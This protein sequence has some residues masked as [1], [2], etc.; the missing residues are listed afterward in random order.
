MSTESSNRL[1][2]G[3]QRFRNTAY[4]IENTRRNFD[5]AYAA[6]VMGLH[7]VSLT[8][9]AV[10]LANGQCITD[11]VRC[12]YLGL[13]NHP[14]VVAGALAAIREYSSVH[15]SCARTRL[16]FRLLEDLEA[17]LSA[18]FRCRTIAYS[19]VMLAN[20]GALP[21]IASGYLTDGMKPIVVFDRLCHVSLAYHKP[22]IADETEVVTI[23][24]N[25]VAALEQICRQHKRVAYI[26]DGVY[27]M[28]GYAPIEALRALQQ[29]YGLFLYID[30]AHGISIHGERGQGYARSQFPDDLGPATIIAASLG[31]GFGASGGIL[32]LGTEEQ[33]N[34]F[35]RYSIPYAFSAAPNLA[36]V[37]A[38]LG[39][40][41]IHESEELKTLQQTLRKR[42]ELFDALIPTEQRGDPLPIRLVSVGAE[43]NAIELARRLLDQGF[44]TSA[45]FF[46]TVARGK[47]GIRI[48]VTA[49]H[50]ADEIETLCGA[51]G[52]LP[53]QIAPREGWRRPAHA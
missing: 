52:D 39:A 19:T 42:I 4:V 22:V 43:R 23:P 29:R 47:A 15:W 25:D 48:C 26:A 45:I 6:G 2:T 12:S 17:R 30:D 10:R 27:S 1:S 33:E 40:T 21:L 11:F 31:K 35:R 16:N 7:G 51:L 46:P 41:E 9:R 24:H 53:R 44:Y 5:G 8:A 14:T 38:A 37:G 50:S 18:L 34:L 32:M 20:L 36:A 13:D 3:D 28:G 49:A